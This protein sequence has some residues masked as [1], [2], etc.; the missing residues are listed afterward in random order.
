MRCE[1]CNTEF[2]VAE[3]VKECPNC[4]GTL[5]TQVERRALS[6]GHYRMDE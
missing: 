3:S 2:S 6:D 1:Y 4:G 5:K